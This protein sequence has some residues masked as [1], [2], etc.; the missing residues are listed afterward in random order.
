MPIPS[1]FLPPLLGVANGVVVSQEEDMDYE[2]GE[3]KS[4]EQIDADLVTLSTLPPSRWKSLINLDLIKKRNK[5]KEPPKTYVAPFFMSSMTAATDQNGPTTSEGSALS[6]PEQPTT[7]SRILNINSGIELSDFATKLSTPAKTPSDYMDLC[8]MLGEM[9]PSR[10]DNEITSL[11][12]LVGGSIALMKN[13]IALIAN[14]LK[15][16]M[17]FETTQAYLSVFIDKHGDTIQKNDEL[18]WALEEVLCHLSS[19]VNELG[20]Y[21]TNIMSFTDYVKSSLF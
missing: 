11:G 12:P 17:Y 8:K 4:P 19:R 1:D 14:I 20:D 2:D 13:F 21:V 10:I 16:N 3:Y 6:K 5:P 7:S 9:G 18:L 15:T